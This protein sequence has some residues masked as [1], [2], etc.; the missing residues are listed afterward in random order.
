MITLYQLL[1]AR[2]LALLSLPAL[3]E[4]TARRNII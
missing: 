3:H 2:L 4:K 1:Y